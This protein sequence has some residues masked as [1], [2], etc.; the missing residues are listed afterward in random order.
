MT[1]I[2]INGVSRT[3]DVDGDTPLLLGAARRVQSVGYKIRLR[4][5]GHP[6]V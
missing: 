4:N 6:E 3:V 5:G 2:N 1:T